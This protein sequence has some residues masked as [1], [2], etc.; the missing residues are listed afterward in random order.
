MIAA[1]EQRRV[2]E[3]PNCK[4]CTN[5]RAINL[6][7]KS[8]VP[9]PRHLVCHCFFNPT[10]ELQRVPFPSVVVVAERPKRRDQ[11]KANELIFHS[12]EVTRNNYSATNPVNPLQF[13][14]LPEELSEVQRDQMTIFWQSSSVGRQGIRRCRVAFEINLVYL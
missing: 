7:C 2:G 1:T 10:V 9:A 11:E 4:N 13:N 3:G 6:Q 12:A 5:S 8:P 14:P